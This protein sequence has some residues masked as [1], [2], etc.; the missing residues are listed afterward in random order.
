MEFYAYHYMSSDG[1]LIFR[2]DNSEHYRGLPYFPHHKH[3]GPDERVFGCP[4]PSARAVGEEIE[5]YIRG[6]G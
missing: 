2:Y 6:N 1:T 4:Q 3:E 5:A